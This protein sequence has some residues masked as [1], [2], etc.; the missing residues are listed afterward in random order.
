MARELPALR[1]SAARCGA[2]GIRTMSEIR[3]IRLRTVRRLA[4]PLLA[5]CLPPGAAA[6]PAA[7]ELAAL[8]NGYRT[9]PQSCRGEPTLPAGSPLAPVPALSGVDAKSADQLQHALKQAGYLAARVQSISVSGPRDARSAMAHIVARHCSVLLDRRYAEFGVRRDGNAWRVVLAQPLL[10]DDLG[11]WADAGRRVLELV[12]AARAEARD[13]GDRRLPAAPPVRWNGALGEAALAHSRD[14]ASRNYFS[15]EGRDGSRVGERATRAG[16]GWRR[17]GENI[18]TGQGS[19][20]HVVSG[21]LSSPSH[22][23]NL[24]SRAYTD[25]GAA[26]AVDPASDTAIYWTQVLGEPR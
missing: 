10:A 5:A 11:D 26:Y 21:W 16:Y 18:A 6:Q 3:S 23:A 25:M 8:I 7:D 2:R 14:M 13:C 15:H 4:G 24:M 9:A 17:I 22:C 20:A 19:P 12:N 1:E